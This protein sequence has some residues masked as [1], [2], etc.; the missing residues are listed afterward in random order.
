MMSVL[1][2]GEVATGE[3]LAFEE[4]FDD[5]EKLVADIN[6]GL[7]DLVFPLSVYLVDHE[8]IVP[9]LIGILGLPDN[10]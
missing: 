2:L 10:A 4:Y 6:L 8:D 9:V 1:V 3:V 7:L 5:V